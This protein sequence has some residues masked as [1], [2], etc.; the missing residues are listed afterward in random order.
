MLRLLLLLLL[1]LRFPPR[2]KAVLLVGS[3]RRPCQPA[4]PANQVGAGA[5]VQHAP[6]SP[7]PR[8][9]RQLV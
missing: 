2:P 1:L 5:A 6:S 7:V 3:R 4:R 8:A 9:A